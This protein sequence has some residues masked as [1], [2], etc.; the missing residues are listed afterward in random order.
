MGQ[1]VREI[2]AILAAHGVDYS[3]CCE[4]SE[5]QALLEQVE[6]SGPEA[7]VQVS[8]TVEPA[9]PAP[10]TH[11]A[12]QEAA[13]MSMGQMEWADGTFAT[14]RSDG[15]RCWVEFAE[16]KDVL[17]HFDDGTD[18]VI[19]AADL[20][21]VPEDA[22]QRPTAFAG[23]FEDARTQ[24]FHSGRLLV[25]EV[26]SEDRHRFESKREG[27]RALVLASE[28]VASLLEENAV[29]WRGRA[30]ELRVPH[31]QQ[32]VGNSGLP[33]LAMVLP[34]AVDAMK[35]LS[36]P[37]GTSKDA[38]VDSF[39]QALEDVEVHQEAAQAR[40]LSEDVQLRMA[41]DEEF[42]EAL[43]VDRAVQEAKETAV[44]EQLM[45][46]VSQSEGK[47]PATPETSEEQ[48][49]LAKMC[50]RLADEFLQGSPVKDGSRS[51]LVLKLPTGERV[52]RAFCAEQN[53]SSV[54]RWA[55]CCALLPEANGRNLQIPADFELSTA[56]PTRRLGA[57]D[58]EKTLSE[59]GLV[60]S[61][62]L[63][64][65]DTSA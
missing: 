35:V 57:E 39:V 53:F 24:A 9:S 43:A 56:F 5:L 7:S 60:P 48:E 59:L 65:I 49:R 14:Q 50:R 2:K 30:D 51:R 45:P 63:L 31:L 4:K 46:E 29:F 23:T 10:E 17:C 13:S 37:D 36:S 34:L 20:D 28:E 32:L 44:A 1:S 55:E 64:L 27:L 12:E 33:T 40:A 6:S 21:P 26:S 54:R 15:R 61:A 47:R 11:A 3:H 42:A 18:A 25:A 62:A 8:P 38:V 22:L 58:S 41:Q 52:E 19:A 16:D